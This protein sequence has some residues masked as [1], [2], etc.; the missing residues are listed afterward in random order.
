MEL[1][2]DKKIKAIFLDIGG[3]VIKLNWQRATQIWKLEP[4]QIERLKGLGTADFHC[5]FEM[6]KLMPQEFHLALNS[7]LTT[8][9]S[10]TKMQQ[11]WNSVID[12]VLP[13]LD[14]ILRS[15]PKS[16]EL[17]CL[18]NTNAIHQEYFEQLAIF[19]FFKNTFYSHQMHLRKPDPEIF[20]TACAQADKKPYEVI[21]IDDLQSNVEAARQV[22]MQAEISFNSALTTKKILQTAGILS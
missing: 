17:Y 15:L 2:N 12:F 3:V 7:Y 1:E 20:L 8:N 16:I 19:S 4:P 18:S 5:Q 13:G 21:F 14:P 22:G 9:L 11:G 6:G 10:F